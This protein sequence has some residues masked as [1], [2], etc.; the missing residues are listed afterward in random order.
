M[1]RIEGIITQLSLIIKKNSTN[2]KKNDG[3]CFAL[4]SC[5]DGFKLCLFNHIVRLNQLKRN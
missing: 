5:K 1:I 3:I 4:S 2:V